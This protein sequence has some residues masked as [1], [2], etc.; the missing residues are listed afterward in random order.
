MAGRRGNQVDDAFIS[1]SPMNH[2][3]LEV[4]LSRNF[5]FGIYGL[6]KENF[7]GLNYDNLPCCGWNC[8][9]EQLG[10]PS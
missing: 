10:K 5:D 3:G 8:Q 2:E 7:Y 4:M 9:L 1:L 6:I